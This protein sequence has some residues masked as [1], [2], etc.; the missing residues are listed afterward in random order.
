MAFKASFKFSDSREFDVL[1]W[2]VKFNRDVDPKGRPAYDIYGGTINVEVES[3]PDTIVLDKMFKQYQPVNGNIV[4][5]KADEDAK[6]KE[7]VF[8]N[9]SVIKYVEALSVANDYPLTIKF[10]I[11][12]QTVQLNEVTFTQDWPVIN[13]WLVL[14]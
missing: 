1:R 2:D 10:T 4:F 12:A 3:T 14:G 9:G 11:S 7:L 13:L 8:E 5:K 6:M